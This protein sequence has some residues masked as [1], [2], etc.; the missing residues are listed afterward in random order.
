[1]NGPELTLERTRITGDGLDLSLGGTLG[2]SEEA[3]LNFAING[4]AYLE[5]IGRSNSDYF[6]GGKA[7]VD[8][9]L[10]GPASAPQLGGDIRLDDV[11]FST[12]DLQYNLEH[13]NG[14]IAMAGEKVTLE[15]FTGVAND[16]AINA[17]GLLTL[18]RLQPKEWRLDV[19]TNGAIVYYQGAQITLNGDV[20]LS[21]DPQEQ[22]LTGSVTVPQAEYVSD[23]DFERL[24]SS[25]GDLS[26][27]LGIGGGGSSLPR[28]N[29][30]IQV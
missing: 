18:D 3:K 13:G 22:F 5:E 7:T 11:S 26:F 10:T 27:D 28:T 9:Q 6:M 25:R 20:T 8:V 30:D 23:F 14:R 1:M 17:K 2:I 15:N 16:G 24:T 4:A 12:L 19:S 21:G 29:L